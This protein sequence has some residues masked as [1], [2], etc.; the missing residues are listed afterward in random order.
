MIYQE[1]LKVEALQK[2]GGDL[3]MGVGCKQSELFEKMGT[4]KSRKQ[5]FYNISYIYMFIMEKMGYMF[6]MEDY[7]NGINE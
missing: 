5:L 6:M 7:S 2:R 3:G 1:Y 4:P